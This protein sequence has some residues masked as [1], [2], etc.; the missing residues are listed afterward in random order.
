MQIIIFDD[1]FVYALAGIRIYGE[2][3]L[4][5]ESD[6]ANEKVRWGWRCSLCEPH[7]TQRQEVPKG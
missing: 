1:R 4:L 6:Y 5:A 2:D 7:W 3:G